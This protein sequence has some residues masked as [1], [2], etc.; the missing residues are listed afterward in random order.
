MRDLHRNSNLWSWDWGPEN[1]W[2]IKFQRKLKLVRDMG[3][4]QLDG[5]LE[6]IEKHVKK[7]RTFLYQLK[8][9][10][11]GRSIGDEDLLDFFAQGLEMAIKIISEVKFFEVK[12]DKYAPVVSKKEESQIRYYNSE[13]EAID[14]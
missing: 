6:D 14:F 4:V 13:E 5:F 12:L 2:E 10:E 3:G 8:N 11:A 9:I 1:A 7:G